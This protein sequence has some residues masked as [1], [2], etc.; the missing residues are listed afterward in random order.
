MGQQ[1]YR[2]RVLLEDDSGESLVRAL[3]FKQD[4]Q[5]VRLLSHHG[6]YWAFDTAGLP[7]DGT[8]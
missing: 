4:A 8:L 2:L 1:A 3:V 7:D 6:R 5:A